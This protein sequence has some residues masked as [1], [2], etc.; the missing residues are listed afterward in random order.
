V[1]GTVMKKASILCVAVIIFSLF[2]GRAGAQIDSNSIVK[3]Y[4]G[5]VSD[6]CTPE[7]NCETAFAS[8][9][10]GYDG[11][12]KLKDNQ[13]FTIDWKD[14]EILNISIQHQTNF[15][16]N[17]SGGPLG[18]AGIRLTF[19]PIPFHS[20]GNVFRI[21]PGKF[22][23]GEHFGGGIP[24]VG[25]TNCTNE[26]SDTMFILDSVNLIISPP[27]SFVKNDLEINNYFRVTSDGVNEM[28][29]FN[30]SSI[31]RNIEVMDMLGRI[32]S[33]ISL[34]PSETWHEVNIAQFPPGCYFARLGDQMAKFIVPPR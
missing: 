2:A 14:S 26:C 20:D 1:F 7:G 23:C 11:T 19:S 15:G 18:Y 9:T 6:G 30:S 25:H 8:D 21:T 24:Y 27:G 5:T 33:S 3:L 32:V 16:N 10:V 29:S 34:S 17:G 12:F 28:F 13:F 22:G 4:L 31:G